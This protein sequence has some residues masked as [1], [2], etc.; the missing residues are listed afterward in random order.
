MKEYYKNCGFIKFE[1]VSISELDRSGF[2]GLKCNHSP[3]NTA[4]CDVIH[5]E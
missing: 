3:Q 2:D 4:P 1:R 5:H